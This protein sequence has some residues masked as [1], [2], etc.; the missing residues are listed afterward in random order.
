[1]FRRPHYIALSVVVIV[2]VI[3][4]SLPSQ[5]TA[6]LKLAL[7]SL[8]LPLFG[9]AGSTQQ[10]AEKAGDRVVSRQTL[11]LQLD[12]LRRENEQLRLLQPQFDAMRT[13]NDRLRAQLG[14]QKQVKWKMRLARVIARDPANW[15]RDLQIDLGSRDQMRAD[16]PVITPEGLVGRIAQVNLT[17]SQVVLVGDPNCRVSALVGESRDHGVIGPS[18]S[19][20]LDTRLVDLTYLPKTAIIKPGQKVS[21]SGLGGIFPKGIA[22]GEIIDSQPVGYGLYTEARV[23]LAVDANRLEEVWVIVP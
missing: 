20:L 18:S 13:E 11:L 2:T 15:W 9:L 22:I 16:L 10:L 12:Q 5:T 23:K 14:F 19:V 3:L 1:M 6:R 4:L 8:F 7:T 21:T 17:H